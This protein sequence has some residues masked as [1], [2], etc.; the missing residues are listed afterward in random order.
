MHTSH[1]AMHPGLDN[2]LVES[3][4]TVLWHLTCD[5]CTAGHPV[6]AVDTLNLALPDVRPC[7][8]ALPA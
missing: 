4:D 6:L 5:T 3:A 2:T 7:D 8:M 1:T